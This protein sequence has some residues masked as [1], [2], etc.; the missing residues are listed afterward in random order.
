MIDQA[1][2]TRS[3]SVLPKK[4]SPATTIMNRLALSQCGMPASSASNSL[5]AADTTASER[6]SAAI[7]PASNS[8]RNRPS[9]NFM[10]LL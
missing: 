2:M 8:Q 5:A 9:S 7:Y 4:T 10:K 3:T 6:I 1:E